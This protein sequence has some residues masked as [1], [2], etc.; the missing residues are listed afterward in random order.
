MDRTV[1]LLAGLGL[2]A[3]LMYLFDPQQGRRRRA[4][5]EDK[6]T[7]AMNE[8]GDVLCK[9]GR[10][11]RQRAQGTA[12]EARSLFTSEDVTDRRLAARVRSKIGRY[13]SHPR[14]IEVAV[15]DGRVT[16]SG[17]ILAHEVDGLLGAVRSVRGVTDIENRLDVHASPGNIAALQGGARRVGERLN[18]MENNWAPATRLLAGTAGGALLAYGFRQGFPVGCVAG[19][20]GLG[21][22]SST[23]ET[24]NG[25]PTA[26]HTPSASG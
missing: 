16:L 10:D 22:T 25:N 20:A 24:A 18:L 14:A 19:T 21:N 17:P 8:T 26:G 15:N 5:L 4:L 7:R 3:G 23:Q 9:A 13:I 11:L 2:G 6:I 12:A 1:N